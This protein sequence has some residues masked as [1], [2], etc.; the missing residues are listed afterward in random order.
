MTKP[1]FILIGAM[2]SATS[3]LHAQ[4]AMQP[5]IFMSTPKEPNYFS[6]DEQYARGEAWYDGLFELAE[7]GDLCGESSTHYTKLPD[8]PQ[9]IERMQ[10]RLVAPKLIYVIRHP[11]DRLVSHYIHQWSQRVISC[12]IN[13]AIDQYHELIAYSCYARQLLPYIEAYGREN[14]LVTCTEAIKASPQSELERVARFIG[15]SKPVVWHDTLPSQNVSQQRI[16]PFPGYG[17]L[18]ESRVMT[19]LR[20]KLVPQS[21]RDRVK[22]GLT[23]KERPVIDAVHMNK[24]VETFDRDLEVLGSWFGR[25]IKCDNF[26]QV[27]VSE[28][29]KFSHQQS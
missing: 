9:T 7:N 17:L 11:V 6:D 5:G 27:A 16:R 20:Q 23:M 26:K 18:V 29:L 3:T 13:Q 10:R 21:I 14:I 1:D 2:K 24:L 15:Y 28:P 4:L 12:D 25:Q 22:S 8:Y 19:F